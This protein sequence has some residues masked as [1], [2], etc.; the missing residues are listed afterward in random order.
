MWSHWEDFS[1]VF[2]PGQLDFS[3]ARELLE[4]LSASPVPDALTVNKHVFMGCGWPTDERATRILRSVKA[5]ASALPLR[6]VTPSTK[7]GALLISLE[8]TRRSSGPGT[9]GSRGMGDG[10]LEGLIFSTS[11]TNAGGSSGY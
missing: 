5:W 10:S 7:W 8:V 6:L 1:R 2:D 3:E 4:F 9:F 11:N